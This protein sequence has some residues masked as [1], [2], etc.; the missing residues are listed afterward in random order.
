MSQYGR[1]DAPPPFTPAE[2]DGLADAEPADLLALGRVARELEAA[3][4]RG[5]VRPSADFAD[6]V[7]RSIATEPSPAPVRAAVAAARRRSF[8]GALAA[9]RDAVRVGLGAGFPV[10]VR[11]QALALVLVVTAVFA[12]GSGMATVGAVRLL[13]GNPMPGFPNSSNQ[14]VPT[15]PA[16]SPEGSLEPIG[17]N[18]SPDPGFSGDPF[19]S[20][21]PDASGSGNPVESPGMSASEMPEATDHSGGGTGGATKTPHPTSKPHPTE[22]PHP[23]ESDHHD[24]SPHPSETPSPTPSPSPSF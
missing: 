19:R 10:A 18:G 7:M 3:A 12:T 5:G 20:D 13:G 9:F 15:L 11:A 1:H 6:R 16:D 14:P 24:H 4:A 2:L 8:G 21:H 17:V 22:T 23:T